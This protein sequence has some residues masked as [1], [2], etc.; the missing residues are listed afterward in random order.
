MATSTI[1]ELDLSTCHP[2]S[3]ANRI[4]AVPGL[5]SS[6]AFFTFLRANLVLPPSAMSSNVST[7]YLEPTSHA[8]L[9][10]PSP[11]P[12]ATHVLRATNSAPSSRA[13]TTNNSNNDDADI[14]PLSLDILTAKDDKIS[15][16]KLVADSIAQQRQQASLNLVFHPLCL[17]ILAALLAGAYQIAWV[18]RDRDLG[19]LLTLASGAVM[20]YLVAIRYAAGPYIQLAE[21]LQWSF[22]LSEDG[23]ED[24]VLGSKY[25]NE[26]IGT[27]VLRLE[28]SGH[29]AGG[30]SGKKKSRSAALKGGKGVIRAWTTRLRYRGKGLGGDLLREAV[31][32]TK[33]RCG[34]DAEVG[35]AKEHANSHMVL[36]EMFNG[37]FRKT[38]MKAARALEAVLADWEGG[39]RKR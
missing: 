34:R 39:R 27:L 32:I 29:H 16:L 6:T 11:S 8:A 33:E 12:L 2:N 26:V 15:A 21:Q 13:S 38:E 23:E 14:P 22:L 30:G 7:P 4:N 9:A 10:P 31:R 3:L 20:S 24:I 25:G 37:P 5:K 35:F 18:R 17:A 28:P 36:P 1:T 19:T